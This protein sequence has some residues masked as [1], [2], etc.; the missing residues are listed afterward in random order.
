V[1]A[2][3]LFHAI[4]VFFAVRRGWRVLPF[5]VLALPHFFAGVIAQLPLLTFGGWFVPTT[6]LVVIAACL[7]TCSLLYTAIADPEPA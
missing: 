7:C 2:L 1:Y 5:A 6:N 3:L 4:L